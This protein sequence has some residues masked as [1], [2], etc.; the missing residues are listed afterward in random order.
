MSKTKRF[1]DDAYIKAYNEFS[2]F[3]AIH[4]DIAKIIATYASENEPC[5]DIGACTSLL[6]VQAIKL[7]R[8]LCVAVEGNKAFAEKA[9]KHPLVLQERLLIT[10]LHLEKFEAILKVHKPTLLIARR[11]LPE[12]ADRGI[13]LVQKLAKV[14]W[15][16]GVKKIVLEG[17]KPVANPKNILPTADAEAKALST[18][19]ELT[20]SYKNVRLLEPK[21]YE[22]L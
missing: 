16:N 3:P 13:E 9:V 2:V 4:T 10:D 14:L 1:D 12:I 6:S 11:V 19:Y 21:T 15:C 5:I 22:R 20:H 8:S 18:Y 17:R 7:G